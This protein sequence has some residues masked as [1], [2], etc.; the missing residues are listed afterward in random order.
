[1]VLVAVKNETRRES[2]WGTSVRRCEALVER[3]KVNRGS[4][5]SKWIGQ[6]RRGP[7]VVAK[8]KADQAKV[9]KVSREER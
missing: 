7:D 9:S 2:G 8:D 5:R 1:M 6:V 4:E 3:S